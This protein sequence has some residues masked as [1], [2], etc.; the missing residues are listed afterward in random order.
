MY[1]G[2]LHIDRN[3]SKDVR[4][5]EVTVHV[6]LLASVDTQSG[7][8]VIAPSNDTYIMRAQTERL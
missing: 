8:L 6:N 5:E 3:H 1:C 2:M 4:L 7:V